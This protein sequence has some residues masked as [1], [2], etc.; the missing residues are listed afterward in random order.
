MLASFLSGC[1]ASPE[2]EAP[3]LVQ[4]DQIDDQTGTEYYSVGAT[5]SGIDDQF[6]SRITLNFAISHAN[7]TTFSP[8]VHITFADG[9]TLTCEETDLRRLPALVEATTDWEFPC[10]SSFP[11]NV[12]GATLV[13]TDT[14]N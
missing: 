14:Y 11:T 10:E 1:A 7:R 3:R 8:L 5:A 9:S 4:F 2:E 12:S 6:G 13:V